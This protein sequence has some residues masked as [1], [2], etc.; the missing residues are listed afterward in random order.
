MHD[1]TLP[2]SPGPA[3]NT[4]AAGFSG[5]P[6][7]RHVM[8][9]ESTTAPANDRTRT[10][11]Q[12]YAAPN[13]DNRHHDSMVVSELSSPVT[14]MTGTPHISTQTQMTVSNL[15]ASRPGSGT[16]QRLSAR[17]AGMGYISP[18]M[19]LAGGLRDTG[20][21]DDDG[22]GPHEVGPEGRSVLS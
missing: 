19:A 17:G 8:E 7:V 11:N 16:Y 13:N 22:R 15:T 21:E 1:E 10:Y 9:E 20:G 14:S 4:T 5:S 18:E 3:R 2:S 6:T 12:D